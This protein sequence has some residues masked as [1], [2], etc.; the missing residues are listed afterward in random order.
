M[1]YEE[2]EEQGIEEQEDDDDAIDD[3][4]KDKLKFNI[5]ELLP[6]TE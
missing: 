5:T 4:D 3:L 1:S 6:N 2:D